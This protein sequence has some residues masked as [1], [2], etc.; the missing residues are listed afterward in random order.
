MQGDV[1][2]RIVRSDGQEMTLND[3]KKWRLPKDALENFA[4]LSYDVSSAEIP[5][6]DGALVTSKR[7][8]SVDR[9]IK[10]IAQFSERNAVLR[11][12]AISFFNPKY[13]FD[14]H[15]TYMGRTRW[16]SG[17]QIG[18]KCS[19]GNI[20]EPAEFEWTILCPRPYMLSEGNFGKD[21]ADVVGKF[22]FPFMSFLPVSDGSVPGF[23]TGFVASVHEFAKTVYIDN[24]GDVESGM[25]VTIKA[26]DT[27]VNPLVRVGDAFIR[28]IKTIT[29]GDVI[30]LDASQ[31]PPVVKYNGKNAMHLVDRRSTVLEMVIPTGITAIEYDADDGDQ[32]MSVV[33]SYDKQYLGL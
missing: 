31:R 30:L 25:K 9:S 28:I 20:Y 12:E 7:V 1:L 33:V 15:I 5:S 13:T 2:V 29:Q 6:Y 26:K 14:C 16:C 17:E 10:A 24:D 23:N 8:S 18:F 19:E 11:A 32:H 3:G 4:N 22:G 27:V 21:I